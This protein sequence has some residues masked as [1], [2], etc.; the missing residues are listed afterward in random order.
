MR[1][2]AVRRRLCSPRHREAHMISDAH[3]YL[4]NPEVVIVGAAAHALCIDPAGAV[5]ELAL[6]HSACWSRLMQA[7]MVPMRGAM[8]RDQLAGPLQLD[9][10][11]LALLLERRVLLEAPT[12]AE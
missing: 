7:L 2:F 5:C 8:L 12:S 10:R 4:R 1:A 11:D 6:R 3:Y 9:V